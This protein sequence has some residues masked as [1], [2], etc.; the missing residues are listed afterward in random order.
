MVLRGTVAGLNKHC[1]FLEGAL[2][3][4]GAVILVVWKMLQCQPTTGLGFFPFDS[5]KLGYSLSVDLG[6]IRRK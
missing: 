1:L 6:V 2:G 5:T 3:D 4:R